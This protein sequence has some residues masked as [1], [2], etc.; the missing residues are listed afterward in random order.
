MTKKKAFYYLPRILAIIYILFLGIFALDVFIPNQTLGYY[1][2]ALFMHLIPNFIL[3][4]ILAVA[5]IWERAGGGLFILLGLI[6]TVFFNTYISWPNFLLI[7]FP[8]FLLGF[9]FI[10]DSYLFQRGKM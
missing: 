6:F 9:L 10:M 3:L 7:S 4:I 8:I 2:I 1:L 5:W